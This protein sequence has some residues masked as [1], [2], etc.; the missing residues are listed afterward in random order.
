MSSKRKGIKKEWEL[1]RFLEA[2]GYLVIRSSASRTG[3]DLIAGNG[4]KVLAFQVQSSEYIPE[5]KLMQL[6]KYANALN[7]KPI[8]AV[9][10]RGK[11]I[12]AEEEDLERIGKM[13][14]IKVKSIEKAEKILK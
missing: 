8:I 5:E 13:W 9:K 4:S 3:I 12:F 7:A 6:K 10:E 14:K 11:W 1:R 2:K